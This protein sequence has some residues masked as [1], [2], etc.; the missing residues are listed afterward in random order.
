MKHSDLVKRAASWLRNTANC[1]VVLSELA[2]HAGQEPDAIGFRT[3]GSFLIECKT[4]R[5]DFRRDQKKDWM[6][7]E[8][9]SVGTWRYYMTPPGLLKPSELPAKWGLLEVHGRSVRL[10]TGRTPPPIYDATRSEWAC[11]RDRLKEHYMLMSAL[12][13]EQTEK[14]KAA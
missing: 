11:E 5:S 12:R 3:E 4:S 14:R 6:R 8:D 13:R 9:L 10:I 7:A 2:T 1:G